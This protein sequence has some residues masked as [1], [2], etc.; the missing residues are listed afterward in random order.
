MIY[1]QTVGNNLKDFYMIYAKVG[2]TYIISLAC[3]LCDQTT[4]YFFNI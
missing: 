4:K 2:K 1:I 3:G